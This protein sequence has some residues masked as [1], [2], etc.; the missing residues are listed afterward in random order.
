MPNAGPIRML[1]V[2]SKTMTAMPIRRPLRALLGFCRRDD[3]GHISHH[4]RIDYCEFVLKHHGA[5]HQKAA[6]CACSH[7]AE[8]E[9]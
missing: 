1:V 9:I 4:E 3:D 7:A 2:T 5:M 8:P 6:R